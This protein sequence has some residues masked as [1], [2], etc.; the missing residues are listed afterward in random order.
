MFLAQI[1]FTGMVVFVKIAREELSTFEVV[2]WRSMFAVP[3]LMLMHHRISWQIRDRKTMLLRTVFG[4]AALCSFF[5][6]A[7]GLYIADLSLI[8]KIQP[9][10]IAILAPLILGSAEKASR[11]L[12][13]LMAVAMVGCAVL[14][15]P[16]WQVGSKYG[17]FA[18]MAAVF[19]AHAHVFIRGL[20]NE[21]PGIVV[22][23][24][25]TGSGILGVLAYLITLGPI[26]LPPTHLWLP[27]AGVG[28]MAT[29][30]QL[31]MTLAYKNTKATTVAIASYAGPLVA[32]VAD[33]LAF[34]VFPTWN[35]Y[36][37]GSIVVLS[38]VLLLR[39]SRVEGED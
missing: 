33:V 3:L 30:G 1:A 37:G 28:L 27:L 32:V 11:Q 12:W 8:S 7:K 21:H 5:G 20:R 39:K 4:F 31:L 35:V 34:A 23:W 2:L 19:S 26:S 36:V 14:L 13:G 9:I 17:L 18:V 38:G 15:A 10:L 24:F 16:S 25:Q 29:L 6:A 22:L